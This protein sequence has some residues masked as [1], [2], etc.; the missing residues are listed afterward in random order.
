METFY[1]HPKYFTPDEKVLHKIGLTRGEPYFLMRFVS[2]AAG[3]D[4]G[5]SGIDDHSKIELA[6]IPLKK[7]KALSLQKENFLLNLKNTG[8]GPPRKIFIICLRL[9]HCM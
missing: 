5:E 7:G 6:R 4:I 1:L 8:T 9:Q 2:F 3:H